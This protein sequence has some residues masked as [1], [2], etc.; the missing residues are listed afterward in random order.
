MMVRVQSTLTHGSLRKF[1]SSPAAFTL[2][3]LLVVIAIIG[4]LVGMLIPSLS[5]AR[6]QAKISVCRS[7]LSQLGLAI[8]VYADRHQERIPRG[9]ACSGPYD[10]ACADLATPQLW[11]GADSHH[12]PSRPIGLGL[13]LKG[14]ADDGRIYYCPADDNENYE[15]E[16]PRI[17]TTADA[18]GSYTY[19]QLDGL[20]PTARQ[21]IL[22]RLGVNTVGGI[23]VPVEALA[24]D[25]ISFGPSATTRHTNHRGAAANVLYQDRSVVTFSNDKN[26]FSL[27]PQDFATA[28][29]ILSRM[30]QVLINADFGFRSAPDKAPLLSEPPA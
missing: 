29:S 16:F 2:I 30:D 19:R 23:D 7:N 3:E 15:E 10:F 12:H 5:K 28:D 14:F 8:L 20:P 26:A 18:Y 17:G 6:D 1:R 24:F 11:I 13:L 4:L 21:G 25:T 27:R 22:S 9:P